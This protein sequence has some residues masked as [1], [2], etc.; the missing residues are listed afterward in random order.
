MKTTID[1]TFLIAKVFSFALLLITPLT[2]LAQPSVFGPY[3]L[4]I[5]A[6]PPPDLGFSKPDSITVDNHKNVWVSFANGVA[7][8]GSDG[9]YSNVIEYNPNG[10]IIGRIYSIL[11]SNDGLKYNPCNKTVWA[12][13]NQDANPALTVI[14]PWDESTKD[15]T[16]AKKPVHGGGFDDVVFLGGK[17]YISASN[18]TLDPNGNNPAPSILSVTKSDGKVYTTPVL[19]GNAFAI[20][21]VTGRQVRTVQTDPDSMTVDKF[22]NLVLDSQADSILLFV[23]NPGTATQSVSELPLTD[24][25]G[26]PVQV[27]DTVFPTTSRGT[28]YFTDTGTNTIYALESG[29]FN[30]D[31]GYSCSGPSIGTVSLSTGVYTPIVTGLNSSHGAVFVSADPNQEDLNDCD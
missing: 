9:K 1:D 26:N 28:I 6:V 22:N 17:I 10:T 30:T 16:Y 25:H 13:R 14:R 3:T 15:F 2:A 5:F 4:R 11:G 8:D 24:G 27:D 12:L 21:R 31:V 23:S 29:S 19:Y 20:N 18:P 7:P